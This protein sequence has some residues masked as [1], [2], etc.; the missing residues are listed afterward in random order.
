[1]KGEKD[2]GYQW[3]ELLPGSLRNI[4]LYRSIADHAIFTWKDPSS[5]MIVAIA[6]DDCLCICNGREQ[7]LRLK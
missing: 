3:Y 5:D 2:A 1:M 6:T 4:G 7:F